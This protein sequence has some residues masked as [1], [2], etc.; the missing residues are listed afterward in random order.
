[1]LDSDFGCWMEPS[2]AKTGVHEK[3]QIIKHQ[4]CHVGVD[5]VSILH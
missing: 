2:M 3:M 1:M 5:I 4:S